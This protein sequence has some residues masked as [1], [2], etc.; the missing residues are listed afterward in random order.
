MNKETNG[1]NR[2]A[3]LIT[4]LSPISSNHWAKE[5]KE[6][7]TIT[8]YTEHITCDT[9]HMT[10]DMWHITYDT[11]HETH[12]MWDVTHSGRWTLSLNFWSLALTVWKLWCFKEWEEKDQCL[13]VWINDDKCQLGQLI[14]IFFSKMYISIYIEVIYIPIFTCKYLARNKYIFIN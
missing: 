11:S 5:K 7:K 1:K 10:C 12:D 9:W 13:T 4:D 8:Y 6:K 2:V 14:F 3:L